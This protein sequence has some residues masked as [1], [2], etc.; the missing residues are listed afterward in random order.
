MNTHTTNLILTNG[1]F[2]RV[3]S[4]RYAFNKC[5]FT[6]TIYQKNGYWKSEMSEN[7]SLG[8]YDSVKD[9]ILNNY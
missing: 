1:N 3:K 5:I 9:Y 6:F 2:A 4:I 8:Y 7:F